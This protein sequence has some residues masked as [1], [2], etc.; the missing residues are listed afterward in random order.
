MCKNQHFSS[1]FML[2]ATGIVEKYRPEYSVSFHA[3]IVRLSKI[4]NLRNNNSQGSDKAS[5][6]DKTSLE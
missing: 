5:H 6:S 2:M 1:V 4:L 3:D